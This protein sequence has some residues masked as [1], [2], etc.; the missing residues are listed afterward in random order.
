MRTRLIAAVAL[1]FAL[2]SLGA[3]KASDS[4]AEPDLNGIWRGYVVEGRGEQPDRGTTHLELTIKDHQITAQRLDG[5]A[6]PLGEGTY[7][8]KLGKLLQMDATQTSSQGKRL[9]YLGI[10]KLED[11]QLHWCVATPRNRRPA[12]FQTRG[13]QFLLILKRQ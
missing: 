4:A 6:G 1:L 3:Q 12:Q 8:I 2:V 13:Q 10:C 7:K 5:E 9:L 11:G